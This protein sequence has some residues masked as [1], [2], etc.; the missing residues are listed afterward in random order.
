[1]V[2]RKR[3]PPGVR[4]FDTKNGRAETVGRLR[5]FSGAWTKSQLCLMPMTTFYEPNY[6]S[7]KPVRWR[8]GADESMFAV[9]GL[10]R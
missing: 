7:G 1:M 8:I 5:S 2:P 6:E 10:L 3:I 9:A 4:P